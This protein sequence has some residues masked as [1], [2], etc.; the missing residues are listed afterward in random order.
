VITGSPFCAPRANNLSTWFY[1]IHPSIGT[2]GAFKKYPQPTLRGDFCCPGQSFTPEPVR[3]NSRPHP[4]EVAEKK[5]F[6]DGL[7]TIAGTGNPFSVKGMAI[8]TYTCNKDM[9]DRSFYDSD[10]DLLIVPEQG[11]LRI[12]TE[13]GMLMVS[14]GELFILPKKSMVVQNLVFEF[15]QVYLLESNCK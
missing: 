8:H 15:Y 11:P 14:P 2:H 10:G 13:C 6:V 1:R 9:I 3:W 4:A 5:D 7:V 12:Q